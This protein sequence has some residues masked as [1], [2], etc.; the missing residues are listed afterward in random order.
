M[1]TADKQ[2]YSCGRFIILFSLYF[3]STIA[4]IDRVL[5]ILY[6]CLTHFINDQIKELLLFFLLVKIITFCIMITVYMISLDEITF[7]DKIKQILVFTICG[8]ILFILGV[9][10][11]I[12]NKYSKK[13]ESP[14]L[15]IRIINGFHL[16]LISIPQVFIIIV[17][18]TSNGSFQGIDVISILFSSMNI[19]WNIIYLFICNNYE[20][21]FDK[22]INEIL[23]E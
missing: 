7:C 1:N 22:E 18:G 17:N 11:S 13:Y 23:Y 3:N 2:Q 19:V 9:H 10:Y 5:Q 12:K 6:Y 20:G 4:L 14:L 8:E 21:L 16:F 15:T